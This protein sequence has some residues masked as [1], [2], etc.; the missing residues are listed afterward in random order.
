MDILEK[1]EAL[2]KREDGDHEGGVTGDHGSRLR[3]D[4]PRSSG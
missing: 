4:V 1:T 3:Q 2:E